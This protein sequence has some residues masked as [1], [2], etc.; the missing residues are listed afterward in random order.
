MRDAFEEQPKESWEKEYYIM[1]AAQWILWNGQGFF[2][3]ILHP[4][5]ISS[6]D[7]G[8]W[9][10]GDLY[11]SGGGDSLLSLERWRFWKEGFAD[12]AAGDEKGYS[13]ECRKLAS[14]A[15]S[16]MEAMEKDM[17]F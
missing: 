17:T 1:A 5:Y 10:F 11:A 15:Q 13:G 4:G 3:H 2:K 14:K 9:R 12:A 6:S 7:E 8:A 16:L